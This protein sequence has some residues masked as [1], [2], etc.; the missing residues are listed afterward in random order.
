MELLILFGSF[1]ILMIISVPIAFALVISSVLT[2]FYSQKMDLTHIVQGM[3]SSVDA[4]TL[5]AVPLFIFAGLLMEH[6][7]LS[8]HLINVSQ[9]FV[10]HIT[11]GLAAVTI[12]ASTF[13][14]AIS[15]SGLATVAAIG[16][17]TIPA[18]VKDKYDTGFSAGVVASDVSLGIN[19]P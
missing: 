5:L 7:G 10:G 19:I 2:L 4:Y 16:G 18:M 9:A 12:L 11:G 14:A 3:F 13:F 15:G 1:I 6:G 17:I 8:K